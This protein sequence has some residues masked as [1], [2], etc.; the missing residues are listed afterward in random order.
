MQ[1]YFFLQELLQ[2]LHHFKLFLDDLVEGTALN[3]KESIPDE[4]LALAPDD[5]LEAHP[6]GNARDDL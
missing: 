6:E 3:S 5:C 2:V 4:L 1:M